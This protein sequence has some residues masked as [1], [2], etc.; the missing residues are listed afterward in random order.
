MEQGAGVRR[1]WGANEVRMGVHGAGIGRALGRA[2]GACFRPIRGALG[3]QYLAK[4]RSCSSIVQFRIV[5]VV[6]HI[7]GCESVVMA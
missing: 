1:A 7:F 3:A 5:V 2:W 6:F 4:C